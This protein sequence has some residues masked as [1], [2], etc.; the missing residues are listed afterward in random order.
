MGQMSLFAGRDRDAD[1]SLGN[2]W[3]IKYLRKSRN[4]VVPWHSAA[5][6]VTLLMVSESG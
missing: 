6:N 4:E 3:N 1:T 2:A 5:I